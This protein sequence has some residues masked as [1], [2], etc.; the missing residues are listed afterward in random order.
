ME[1]EEN[2]V[3]ECYR[4]LALSFD[5]SK[6]CDTKHFLFFPMAT[7]TQSLPTH[8][9]KKHFTTIILLGRGKCSQTVF[10]TS[11][12]ESISK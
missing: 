12:Y 3:K 11:K 1:Y 5:T 7:V 9:Y 6:P 10:N 2:S 4:A 8:I